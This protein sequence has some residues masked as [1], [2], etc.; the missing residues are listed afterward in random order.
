MFALV[1][2]FAIGQGGP[3]IGDKWSVERTYRFLNE[4]AAVDSS[5][6]EQIDYLI[7]QASASGLTIA[8][9]RRTAVAGSQEEVSKGSKLTFGASGAPTYPEDAQD[10]IRARVDRMQWSAAEDRKGVSWSRKFPLSA[11]LPAGKVLVRPTSVKGDERALALTYTEEGSDVR[12]EGTAVV[13]GAKRIVTSLKLTLRNVRKHPGDPP[14][15]VAV[16]QALL[17]K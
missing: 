2:L 9:F 6:T 8:V 3:A 13:A 7:E 15:I 14:L 12:G 11:G 16:N 17:S 5:T 1:V 4:A 10:P